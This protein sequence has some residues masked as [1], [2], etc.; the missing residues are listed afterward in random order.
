[1]GVWHCIFSWQI[2]T[3]LGNEDEVSG[4][5]NDVESHTPGMLG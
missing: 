2:I 4:T 1:M 3:I 5:G